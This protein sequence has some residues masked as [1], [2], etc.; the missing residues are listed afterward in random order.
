[1]LVGLDIVLWNEFAAVLLGSI[2]WLVLLWTRA[3][4]RFLSKPSKRHP[5]EAP[6]GLLR[7]VLVLEALLVL[8]GSDGPR[9][10]P[11]PH[12]GKS[13][14]ERRDYHEANDCDNSARSDAQTI[15]ANPIVETKERSLVEAG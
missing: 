1:M 7:G 4:H 3:R 6:L 14:E 8:S 15:P 13:N 5:E 10:P 12:N 11:S 2:L 9:D